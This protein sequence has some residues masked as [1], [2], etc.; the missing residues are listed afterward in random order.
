MVRFMK[1]MVQSNR[2]LHDNRDAAV[3]FIAKEMQLKPRHALKGWE[4]YT[5]NRFWSVDGEPNIEG[6]KHTCAFTQSCS[7]P[8]DPSPMCESPWS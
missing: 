4:Y 7:G 3:D 6:M 1:A 2:W 8:S 5:R